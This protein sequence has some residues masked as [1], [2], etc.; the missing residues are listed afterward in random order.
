MS[1]RLP[2]PSPRPRLLTFKYSANGVDVTKTFSFDETYV[3]HADVQVTRNGSPVR[4]LISWP[5]GFGD[6]DNASA[7]AGAQV[8]F[9]RNATE[10]HI[11]PKKVSGGDT[12]N[13]P[14]DWAG[15]SDTYFA[16]IFLPDNPANATIATLHNE[17]DVAKTI[18]RT[19]FG[20]SSPAKGAIN[21]SVLGTALGDTSGH[22]QTR[23]YAGPKAVNVLRNIYSTPFNGKR[24]SLE[25]LLEFGFWGIVG[26]YL[27][28]A[29]QWIH[30]HIVSNWGWAIIVLTLTINVLLLPLRIKTMQSG[31]KMQRIQPQMDAIKEKYK[32]YKI[33]D[34]K[35]NEM[36]M[37]I[38]KLQKDNGVNMFGGCIPT[39]VQLPLLFAFFSMLPKVVELRHAHWGWLPDLTARRPVAHPAHRH[40]RQPVPHAVLHAVTRR[41]PAAAEDDGL[42]DAR[43]L[44]LLRLELR[45]GPRPLLGRRK[46]LRHRPADGHE[47]H[48]ARPRDARD[49]CQA[50]PPQGR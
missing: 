33:N 16:A 21:V 32:K 13:G 34:P 35:R 39:L 9:S 3:L 28:L 46:L 11:A 20:S 17:L 37:E 12:L 4:A 42:H 19:G 49:R 25:P 18:K 29:L 8:D 10:E 22:T 26:K 14:F 23:I 44:R 38:M 24:V 1:P 43:H 15:I 7:Y 31:L 27:F 50:S 48:L 6:Q 47:P 2:E 45:L 5:G 41:R 30:L 40:G 36:N